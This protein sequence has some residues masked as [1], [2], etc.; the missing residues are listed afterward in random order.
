MPLKNSRRTR[1]QMA[2]L[3]L[4]TLSA[5]VLSTL[6]LS[7]ASAA[8][9]GKLTVLS[10]LGQ[11]LRAEIEVSAVSKEEAGALVAKLASPEAYRQANVELNAA[12]L[13]LRFAV[14][15]RGEKATI[16]VSSAQ[17]IN[18]PFVDMLL[19]L[20]GPGGRLIREYTFLLDPA[21]LRATQ[22]AQVSPATRSDMPAAAAVPAPRRQAEPVASSPAAPSRPVPNR[23]AAQPRGQAG[24]AANTEGA[25]GEYQVKSGD[26]LARIAGQVKPAG[27]SLDQMLVALYR[28]NPEAF[29]GENMNRLRAGRILTVPGAEDVRMIDQGE[30]RQVVLTQSADFNAYRSKLASQ[31]SASE[32]RKTAESGQSVS[33]KITAKVEEPGA[34]ANQAKDKLTLSKADAGNASDRKA[35]GPS[36]EDQ[37]AKDKALAEAQARMRELE[38]NV[39]DLQKLLELKNKGLA[40]QQD[41]AG[42][43]SEEPKVAAKPAEPANPATAPAAPVAPAAEAPAPAKEAA[44]EAGKASA[45][46]APSASA[47][48]ANPAPAKP[49][50]VLVPAPTPEPSLVDDLIGSPLLPGAGAVLLLLGALGIYRARRS[51]QQKNFADSVM[52]ESSLKTNSLIGTTGGQ[53]IDTSNSVFNS[54]FSPTANQLDSNEVDPVAEADVYIAY[55]RDAQAEEI[56][57]EA[58]R[59]QPERNAVRLKL[60]EIYS[61]R[62]DARA[63]EVVASELYASTKGQGED[64]ASAAALGLAL[65]P[66]N[67]LYA[68]DKGVTATAADEVP[69]DLGASTQPLAMDEPAPARPAADLAVDEPLAFEQ[70]EADFARAE[71]FIAD[72]PLIEA[73]A[74]PAPQPAAQEV[75][76][77]VSDLGSNMLDFDLDGISAKTPEAAAEKELPPPDLSADLAGINFDFLDQSTSET[78]KPADAGMDLPAS[79]STQDAS[80]D[81][82]IASFMDELESG[83]AEGAVP[84]ASGT[85]ADQSELSATPLDF[86]L[87]DI[88][89]ELDDGKSGDVAGAGASPEAASAAE[90]ATKLDLALAYHEIGDKEG[91]RE[92]LDE[93]IKGGT[94]EQSERARSLLLELA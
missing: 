26:S 52:P 51:K 75:E 21:E 78:T 8:G 29:A 19:E 7:Q 38:R 39:S 53:S 41:K 47:P 30:A 68:S 11:P 50:A 91:A 74:E 57:K 9:L 63:F 13:S 36:A 18:E 79:Q 34:P 73:Q 35:V 84:A 42:L 28:A 70:P 25:A 37:I 46:P 60:L 83:K 92:L 4:K 17:P 82:N 66:A 62:K 87:S 85:H 69:A 59:T 56:L 43:K 45:E 81:F 10:A 71:P 64:W 86:D 58:L 54:S 55:G 67:P 48:A 20:T 65:D 2:F 14:D 44:T 23:P 33:G 15:Q 32:A 5:A 76:Q 77:P 61:N 6:V 16:R 80:A 40:E 1:S 27:V 94:A 93:V 72:E 89:L 12:L 90:M 24:I 3:G 31:V 22:S 88:S 49:K